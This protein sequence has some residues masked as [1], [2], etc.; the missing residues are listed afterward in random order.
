MRRI[1]PIVIQQELQSSAD[2]YV[3]EGRYRVPWVYGCGGY[4]IQ[5]IE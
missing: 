1:D 2:T 5:L 4:A 3:T